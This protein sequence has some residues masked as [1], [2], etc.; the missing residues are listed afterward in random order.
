MPLPRPARRATF[1][2]DQCNKLCRSSRG[3]KQHVNA[4]HRQIPL[5]DDGEDE[6]FTYKFHPTMNGKSDT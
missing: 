1:P 2:C 5:E 4:L 3:L 6:S